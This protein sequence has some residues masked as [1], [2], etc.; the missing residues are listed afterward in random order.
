MLL[1]SIVD[2]TQVTRL[3][4]GQTGEM[5]RRTDHFSAL[6]IDA[7]LQATANHRT[8]FAETTL[9]ELGITDDTILRVLTRPLER[10]Q[11]KLQ[12]AAIPVE[13]AT[14]A[15]LAPLQSP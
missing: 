11:T 3:T 5:N 8:R 12:A 10:R 9:R 1:S 7:V 6:L 2:V 14:P 4:S 13:Q 15:L